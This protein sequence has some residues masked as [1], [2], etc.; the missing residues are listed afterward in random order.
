MIEHVTD[1]RQH[2]C[3]MEPLI[4]ALANG[5]GI[6]RDGRRGDPATLQLFNGDAVTAA[7]HMHVSVTQLSSC[8]MHE[9]APW[10]NAKH[11]QRVLLPA[12]PH[13]APHSVL[14]VGPCQGARRM[15]GGRM[16]HVMRAE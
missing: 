12:R 3:M 10:R 16:F 15:C 8:M 13:G 14:F 6:A 5:A 4:N 9:R 1:V 11:G 2:V 7:R